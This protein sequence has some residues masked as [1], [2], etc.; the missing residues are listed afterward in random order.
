MTLATAHNNLGHRANG[1]DAAERALEHAQ[2]AGDDSL[3]LGAYRLISTSVIWGPVPLA[4]AFDRYGDLID[5]VQ[6]G[7]LKRIAAIQVVAAL[8]THLGHVTEGRALMAQVRSMYEELG[9]SLSRAK[10]AFVDYRGPLGDGD[11][12]AAEAIL[13]EACETLERLGE[14]GWYSTAVA[15]QAWALYELGRL[16]EAYRVTQKS[17]AAGA[18]DDVVTQAYW[19]AGRAKVL[20]Q[21]GRG[22]EAVA[23]VQE[24]VHL[25]DTTDG[26]LDQADVYAALGEVARL[27]GRPDEARAALQES[28]KRY[29][30]K[31][32]QPFVDQ[33]RARLDRLEA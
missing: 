8:K 6:G 7:P 30:A 27:L 2:R 21:W 20:A 1:L 32:A 14:R 18:Q 33:M 12:A 23:L 29:E 15:V 16:D 9:D 26:L 4:E 13:A 22:D 3:V 25:I 19:R 11:F 24:A 28:I 17:E 10:T 31:G 5:R